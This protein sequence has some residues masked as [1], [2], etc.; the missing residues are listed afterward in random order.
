MDRNI[1]IGIVVVIVLVAGGWWYLSQSNPPAISDTTQQSA[2]NGTQSP[3]NNQ[4][5]Q[6]AQTAPAQNSIAIDQE[7]LTTTSGKP[8]VSGSA[9][10]SSAVYV[11]LFPITYTGAR[12]YVS[13]SS[14]AQGD[15]ESAYPSPAVVLN[16]HWSA[17]FD[18]GR[19]SLAPGAYTVV[20]FDSVSHALLASGALTV[21]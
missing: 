21:K 13:V 10:G 4:P 6:S 17:T 7:T 2:D 1:W 9:S 15:T 11:Y 12:D 3:V 14:A 5:S 16:G 19:H 8:T 18:D 20:V